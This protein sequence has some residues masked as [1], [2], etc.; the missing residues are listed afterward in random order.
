[1]NIKKLGYC[2]R[3][4]CTCMQ[5]VGASAAL[6]GACMDTTCHHDATEHEELMKLPSGK[7]KPVAEIL[8]VYTRAVATPTVTLNSSASS[9]APNPEIMD[10]ISADI[11]SR[12]LVQ[13]P[14]YQQARG[15][16]VQQLKV[17]HSARSDNA[18][19]SKNDAFRASTGSLPSRA[20]MFDQ[21]HVGADSVPGKHNDPKVGKIVRREQRTDD[22]RRSQHAW[23]IG[24]P[25]QHDERRKMPSQR[26]CWC[27]TSDIQ[28][29]C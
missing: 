12:G 16:A 8:E 28:S 25:A 1:M 27:C 20:S 23:A 24:R 9:S 2:N 19:S 18:E 11:T 29:F 7:W 6:D 15:A 17:H 21:P 14:S 22:Q 13:K 4:N 10:L 26:G 5:F 3:P